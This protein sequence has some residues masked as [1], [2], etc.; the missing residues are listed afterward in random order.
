MILGLI[1]ARGGSKGIPR[2]NI[3]PLGG[4]PLIQWT[5][6]AARAS[7]CLDRLVVSTEDAE[8][9]AVVQGLGVEVLDRPAVLARDETPM[10]MVL[11]HVVGNIEWDKSENIL[12]LLQPTSPFRDPESIRVAVDLIRAGAAVEVAAVAPI[13]P[14][15]SPERAV[16]LRGVHA[17]PFF[18]GSV[19]ANRHEAIRAYYLEGSV[20]AY[21]VFTLLRDY[22]G[23]PY[24]LVVEPTPNLDEPEDWAE[25]ERRLAGMLVE[26]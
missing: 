18:E 2:K 5:I 1:P 24:G 3:K 6:E 4:K 8:I 12:V 13:P 21:Y 16:N 22:G 20:Y 9:K 17:A 23:W 14:R 11:K 7:K 19:P 25:A 26:A 15:Y 10:S